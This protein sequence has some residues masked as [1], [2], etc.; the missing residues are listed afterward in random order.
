[1]SGNLPPRLPAATIGPAGSAGQAPVEVTWQEHLKN[2]P[3]PARPFFSNPP[4]QRVED[5]GTYIEFINRALKRSDFSPMHLVR[6]REFVDAWWA[7]A[8]CDRVKTAIVQNA[9][10]S[11]ARSLIADWL[12]DGDRTD[13]EI[14][15]LA[16]RYCYLAFRDAAGLEEVSTGVPC[17]SWDMIFAE[18]ICLAQPKLESFSKYQA[19]VEERKQDAIAEYEKAEA[20]IITPEEARAMREQDR[21][22]QKQHRKNELEF[23][24][25]VLKARKQ[26]ELEAKKQQQG[27]HK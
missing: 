26:E 25:T 6:V 13:E 3:A 21:L 24:K 8:T 14:G 12:R 10:R 2:I 22:E 23:F 7:S 19:W 11:A 27:R 17:F 1:M 18:A 20:E 9:M 16:D 5:D 15:K 4:T